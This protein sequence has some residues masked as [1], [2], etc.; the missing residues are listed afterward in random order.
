MYYERHITGSLLEALTDT[1]V[2]LL[3]GPRQAGKSTLVQHIANNSHPAS[4]L[5]FDDLGVLSAAKG[6]PAGFIQ[7]F[8]VP[9]ILDEI[10][11]APELFSV[12]KAEVDRKRR[13][14]RFLLT[15]SADVML[16]PGVS[17]SLAGRMEIHTL[18]SL[19]QGEIEGIQE[20]FVDTALGD[21]FILPSDA[22]EERDQILDRIV[23][24][25][26]PEILERKTESRRRA[27][28]NA[29]I[30]TILQRD[31]RDI[32]HIEDLMVMPRLMS[33]LAARTA[34]LVNYAEISRSS[35]IAQSTLKRYMA[36][37]ELA[38]LVQPVKPWSR[39]LSHRLVKAP[40]IFFND[41][42]L[43][44][45]LLGLTKQG[46][47]NMP[48]KL[49]AV[50]ENFVVGELRKQITWSKER[51]GLF[52]FRTASGHEVDIILEDRTGMC[53]GIEVKASATV[54]SGDFN[55][56]RFL[57]QSLGSNFRRGILLYPGCESIPFGENLAA[58]PLSAL[59]RI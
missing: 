23:A 56:L 30:T 8:D 17:E 13:A 32:S 44:V 35:G 49:G 33:L 55:G 45:H 21:S 15:G 47:I 18:Y 19:S 54:S 20:T 14:G 53:T 12:I 24:G 51:P 16:L 4:Y 3:N 6:D 2:V 58:L 1:P 9:V 40:R 22:A 59:W 57:Q 43:L 26:Y 46:L 41:S 36:L 52:H 27:W 34:S 38:F 11:K 31:V 37:L 29:Y 10:Q 28:F 48:D 5:T 39:N 7:S 25:G 50:L 42:G